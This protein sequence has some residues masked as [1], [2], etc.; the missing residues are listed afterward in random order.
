MY[1]TQ[2][3]VYDFT[4]DEINSFKIKIIIIIIVAC[5]VSFLVFFLFMIPTIHEVVTTI[6]SVK[7][8]LK[9]ISPLDIVDFKKILMYLQGECDFKRSGVNEKNNDSGNGNTLL[10][11][12]LSPFAIFEDD[13]SLLFANNSFYSLLGTSREA[14]IGLPL[15]DI[16][17][18]VLPFRND[19]SHPFNTLLNLISRIQQG[20]TVD[21]EIEIKTELEFQ[22]L[23]PCPIMIKLVIISKEKQ[24]ENEAGFHFDLI[25]KGNSKSYSYVIF[26]N[27]LS[28]KEELEEK[29][30]F[31]EETSHKLITST[32]P[33]SLSSIIQKEIYLNQENSKIFQLRCFLSCL[34]HL[35]KN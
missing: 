32:I 16:F 25:S 1:K 9:H 27:D 5:V 30:K 10:N 33:K 14:S 11:A 12:M 31:E 13:L 4:H 6:E 35:K 22:E 18:V 3:Y 21:K 15:S 7:L 34:I 23:K 29:I 2:E 8:P 26:I 20:E 24:N 28:N 17:S 19:E